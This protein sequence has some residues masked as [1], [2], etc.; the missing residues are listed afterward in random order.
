MG[1]IHGF[2][3]LQTH[4]HLSN[5]YTDFCSNVCHPSYKQGTYLPTVA[6]AWTMWR[7]SWSSSE[8]ALVFII[9]HNF[10]SSADLASTLPNPNASS[11]MNKLN[12]IGSNTNPCRTPLL[13]SLHWEN[14]LFVSTH[15][16][17]TCCL[18]LS[19]SCRTLE[20]VSLKGDAKEAAN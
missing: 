18:F 13:T 4:P 2:R 7:S 19:G 1:L 16:S 6:H 3:S 8:S 9:L 14:C 12:S 5:S 15:C 17:S 20:D 10:M 11:C